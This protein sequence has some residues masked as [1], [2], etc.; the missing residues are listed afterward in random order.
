MKCFTIFIWN[1]V[2]P[3]IDINE[4]IDDDLN[5][6]TDKSTCVDIV[7]SFQCSCHVGTCLEN[8]QR[9]CTS[10]FQRRFST[11][12]KWYCFKC[13]ASIL[14][15]IK[16]IWPFLRSTHTQDR[17]IH[18]Y[19]FNLLLNFKLILEIKQKYHSNTNVCDMYQIVVHVSNGCKTYNNMKEFK[20]M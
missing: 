19:V 15:N 2:Y 12:H 13:R 18:E 3:I 6:C 4:C 17:G 16:D 8:D 9:T 10:K 1:F 11:W 14:H 20:Y 7:G 5:L